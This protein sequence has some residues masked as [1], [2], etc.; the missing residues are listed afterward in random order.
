MLPNRN[1]AY[2]PARPGAAALEFAL[3]VPV[4]LLIILGM[5]ELGGGFATTHMLNNAAQSGCGLGALQGKS[6]SDIQTVITNTLRADG[7]SSQ[8]VTVTVNDV[9]ADA[10]TAKSGDEI[11]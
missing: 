1:R 7:I 6:T 8:T 5:M 11:S 9:V 2:S 3:T 10:S 4:F